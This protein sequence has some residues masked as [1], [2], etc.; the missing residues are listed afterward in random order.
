MSSRSL[1]PRA[2]GIALLALAFAIP[3]FAQE[4]FITGPTELC[5]GE[6]G[7]LC[8]PPSGD[9]GLDW[10]LPD[11]THTSEHCVAATGGGV[12]TLR[13][14][15]WKTGEAVECTH[16]VVLR[17]GGGAE[18]LIEGPASGCEGATVT[19]CGPGSAASWS[20]SGPDG[21]TSDQRC[22]DVGVA[23]TYALTI[24]SSAE[25]GPAT[26]ECSHDVSF[27]RCIT[28]ENCPRPPGF[29]ASQCRSVRAGKPPRIASVQIAQVASCVDQQTAL[30]D[31]SADD[32]AFCRLMMPLD[33]DLRLEAKRQFAG[34]WANVCAGQIGV[35]PE[36]GPPVSLDP[37]A[38]VFINGQRGTVSAWL[39]ISEARLT[40]LENA[41]LEDED[42]QA[43]YREI[44]RDG[45]MINDGLGVE[46]P[47]G[48]LKHHGLARRDAELADGG[49]AMELTLAGANPFSSSAALAFTIGG[50]EARDV[51]IGVYDLTGRLVREIASGR[52]EPGRHDVRW[53]G[54]DQ[55]G[56]RAR[57][58]V[59]F[60]IG[61]VG[62]G[63]VS[64]RLTLVR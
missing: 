58:G 25:C 15:D 49:D 50:D 14:Y 35:D 29:W 43:M 37:M 7:E 5:P 13:V 64:A 10:T 4:C 59:Y 42:V 40:V 53:D 63:R 52:F 56:A 21:F 36:H 26:L 30:F 47:C 2:I 3:A 6:T 23:G 46:P 39:V 41:S 54:L 17:G 19:L 8:G 31:W 1:L 16:E 24:P 51:R 34:V 11:G 62:Q 61:R 27:E 9:Y 18:Y 55:N 28:V 20:W 22:V 32:R 48:L 45:G 60:V 33:V 57:G 44:I 38:Q 12:W